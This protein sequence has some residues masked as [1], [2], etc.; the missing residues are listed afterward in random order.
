MSRRTI[1]LEEALAERVRR[2]ERLRYE[3]CQ[4]LPD[5][6]YIMLVTDRQTGSTFSIHAGE[7]LGEA[8]AR[9]DIRWQEVTEK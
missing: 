7:T 1:Q 8:L 3:G 9:L 4:R 2:L 5:G 6:L